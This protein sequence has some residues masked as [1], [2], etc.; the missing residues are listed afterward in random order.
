MADAQGTLKSSS[1]AQPSAS[2][3]P[4]LLHIARLCSLQ[5]AMHSDEDV[6]ETDTQW[7][8]VKRR[9]NPLQM[10]LVSDSY[11]T[12]V[13][14]RRTR[15]LSSNQAYKP[16]KVQVTVDDMSFVTTIPNSFRA[17]V[18]G[19]EVQQSQSDDEASQAYST[20]MDFDLA[21]AFERLESPS[22]RR[23]IWHIESTPEP[24]IDIVPSSPQLVRMP[25]WIPSTPIKQPTQP[26]HAEASRV[27]PTSLPYERYDNRLLG[28]PD[29][30]VGQVKSKMPIGS[31]PSPVRSAAVPLEFNE[32]SPFKTDAISQL[33][34]PPQ[35]V[36]NSRR[37]PYQSLKHAGVLEDKEH[38]FVQAA[39]EHIAQGVKRQ[40]LRELE[41]SCIPTPQSRTRPMM[42][43]TGGG[44]HLSYTTRN[45]N[46]LDRL[47]EASD[48]DVEW[49]DAV[50][51]QPRIPSSIEQE[52]EVEGLSSTP[53]Q[54]LDCMPPPL[55][56]KHVS[57]VEDSQYQDMF[58]LVPGDASD[59]SPL[60][61][62]TKTK[63]LVPTQAAAAAAAPAAPPPP[64]LT[65][66]SPR[67]SDLQNSLLDTC[68]PPGIR[69][70]QFSPY[71]QALDSTTQ[72][73]RPPPQWSAVA[74]AATQDVYTTPV[75]RMSKRIRQLV[76]PRR[77]T[78]GDHEREAHEGGGKRQKNF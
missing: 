36:I 4:R 49:H 18:P 69:M 34:T 68:L 16:S 1:N 50:E 24:A 41:P 39:T 63:H 78:V 74:S 51:S 12:T 76:S 11:H 6:F 44:P 10:K 22:K 38:Q 35:T 67:S 40:P 30:P 17:D 64:P 66:S 57:T 19:V 60:H 72:S 7:I 20:P 73:L 43:A 53:T 14:P 42:A 31:S 28:D 29:T 26:R 48:D 8:S 9:T 62:G 27:V 65:L 45:R 52:H 32:T 21:A 13:R 33:H 61:Q 54:P 23:K 2:A 55:Q 58:D 25:S 37:A 56:L 3:T 5:S 71:T 46:M 75:K 15:S 59:S 77:A 47:R 70:S